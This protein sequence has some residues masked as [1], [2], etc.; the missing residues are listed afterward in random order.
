MYRF[1]LALV[2]LVC[3][4]T[5]RKIPKDFKFGTSTAAFQVEGAWNVSGRSTRKVSKLKCRRD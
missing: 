3:E 1:I 5:S 4:G 2:L